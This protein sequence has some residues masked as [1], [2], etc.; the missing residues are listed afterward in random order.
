M[1]SK[2]LLGVLLIALSATGVMAA[3]EP[4]ADGLVDL[5]AIP[6]IN[7][8][9]SGEL[10]ALVAGSIADRMHVRDA[11]TGAALGDFT[12]DRP[13]WKALAL[14][15][16]PDGEHTVVGVLQQHA[17]GAIRV[18][19][20]DAATGAFIRDIPFLDTARTA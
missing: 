5:V 12:I 11:R 2:A 16:V 6:D 13:G 9:S 19:L 20:R 17:G 14:V 3:A 7:G 10:V 15:G 1:P 18:A 4:P 8:N